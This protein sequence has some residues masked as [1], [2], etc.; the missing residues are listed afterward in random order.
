MSDVKGVNTIKRYFYI[1]SGSI[2]GC[3]FVSG[4]RLMKYSD[5]QIDEFL[6]QMNVNLYP[7]QKE[8]FE[9]IV[10][11]EGYTYCYASEMWSICGGY[12]DKEI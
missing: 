12:F 7:R 6:K 3:V 1:L 4:G 2:V 8:V 11:D 5:E 10:N 9:R